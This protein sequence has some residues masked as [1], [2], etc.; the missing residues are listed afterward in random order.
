MQETIQKDEQIEPST[1]PQSTGSQGG[2]AIQLGLSHLV[3]GAV[4]L[5]LSV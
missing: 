5:G 3:A 4:A 2:T 1:L